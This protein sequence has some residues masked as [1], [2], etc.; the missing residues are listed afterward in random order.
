MRVRGSLLRVFHLLDVYLA[1]RGE[2]VDRRIQ[3]RRAASLCSGIGLAHLMH[4][5]LPA[6]RPEASMDLVCLEVEAPPQLSN[7]A[8]ELADHPALVDVVKNISGSAL[9]IVGCLLQRLTLQHSLTIAVMDPAIIV[10]LDQQRRAFCPPL[11]FED[12]AVILLRLALGRLPKPVHQ[13]RQARCGREG[14]RSARGVGCVA[15]RH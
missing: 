14:I 6:E 3:A 5:A 11:R 10:Q 8:G 4:E 15:A 12:D 13:D 7:G 2:G 9:Q 1:F